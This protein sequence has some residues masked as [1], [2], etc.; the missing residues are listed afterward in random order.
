MLL[1]LFVRHLGQRFVRVLGEGPIVQQDAELESEP[2]AAFDLDSNA[3]FVLLPMVVIAVGQLQFLA[4]VL[5]HGLEIALG[6]N[7]TAAELG[8]LD[9]C[10]M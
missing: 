6:F 10:R 5:V 2:F 1:T 3:S 8:S 7:I 9:G 4:T